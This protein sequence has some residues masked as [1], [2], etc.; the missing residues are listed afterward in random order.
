MQSRQT[1]A[2][3]WGI[4][5]QLLQRAGWAGRAMA[6]LHGGSVLRAVPKVQSRLPAA[7]SAQQRPTVRQE[8]R[9][10]QG[11]DTAILSF[12]NKN[13]EESRRALLTV[14]LQGKFLCM[15]VFVCLVGWLLYLRFLSVGTGIA[16]E[17]RRGCSPCSRGYR[18]CKP[19]RE[20]TK[21]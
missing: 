11:R 16:V 2:D 10:P 8:A 17:A 15:Y 6:E 21:N 5:P 1:D 20:V 19:L 3:G 18:G 9:G 13:L 4:L 12:Q 14:P 7:R